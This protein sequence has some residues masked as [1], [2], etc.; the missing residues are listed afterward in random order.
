M[1][2]FSIQIDPLSCAVKLATQLQCPTNDTT[3]LVNC[4]RDVTAEALTVAAA[5]IGVS[6]PT[7]NCMYM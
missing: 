7:V 6:G 4:L 5:E 3:E 2:P 1:N